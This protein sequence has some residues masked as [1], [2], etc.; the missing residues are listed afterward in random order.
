[1]HFM[2]SNSKFNAVGAS[3]ASLFLRSPYSLEEHSWNS[4]LDTALKSFFP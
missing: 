4:S 1:M 2:K 3:L